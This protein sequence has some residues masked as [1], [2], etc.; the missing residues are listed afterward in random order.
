[1]KKII[2]LV[3]IM[4]SL[5]ANINNLPSAKIVSTTDCKGINLKV[6]FKTNSDVI[7]RSSLPQL[8]DF[9]NFMNTNKS[10]KAE[11]AGYT[12]SRGSDSYN[13]ALSQKRAKAV[14][15]QLIAD[16]VKAS[17]L[18]YAGYGKADPVAT[19]KTEAGRRENR[20]IEAKLF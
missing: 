1:M 17:R 5:F 12:D 8:Q 16:G 14:Y 10:K 4:S 3:M 18:T 11:I 15:K 2:L 6:N 19:N 20:R 7:E 13:L 9:A